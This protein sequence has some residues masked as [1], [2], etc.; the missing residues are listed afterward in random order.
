M[1]ILRYAS[2]VLKVFQQS[3]EVSPSV[4]SLCR[5]LLS[6]QIEELKLGCCW[7]KE[8]QEFPERYKYSRKEVQVLCQAF[9]NN[10]SL[11]KVSIGWKLDCS[12]MRVLLEAIAALPNLRSLTLVLH[13]WIPESAVKAICRCQSLRTLD[14][15]G[16]RVRVPQ[17]GVV[18]NAGSASGASAAANAYATEDYSRYEEV[19]IVSIMTHLA[20]SRTIGLSNVQTLKLRHCGILDQDITK[21]CADLKHHPLQELSLSANR[22]IT[23]KG[24]SALLQANN[25]VVLQKLDLTECGLDMEDCQGIS[26]ALLLLLSSSSNASSTN[27]TT[28]T[29]TYSSIQELS[30][31]R[32]TELAA[33]GDG[34][35]FID[36]FR[37]AS[38]R[39]RSLD[40]SYCHLSGHHLSDIFQILQSEDCT[41]ESLMLQG[42]RNVPG[43]ALVN[44]VARNQSLKRLV[45]NCRLLGA[46]GAA[47]AGRPR[48]CCYPLNRHVVQ[49]LVEVIHKNFRLQKLSLDWENGIIPAE[50]DFY[51]Q[52]NRAGRSILQDGVG[53]WNNVLAKVSNQPD[54]LFWLLQNGAGSMCKHKQHI[55]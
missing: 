44:V 45:L 54:A 42:C 52:L 37:V 53:S 27:T 50:L 13:T 15:R 7:K 43:P 2:Q 36:L 28:T 31:A 46:G 9:S 30:L 48:K 41:L 4:E 10:T 1:T 39:L 40:L 11:Q 55:L 26:E 49:E 5:R 35:S 20:H 34:D 6:D 8:E 21:L 18:M 29:T 22:G 17:S 16:V 24:V 12:T 38:T 33:S 14:I 19:N 47:A 32:N 23:S 51:L 3:P 25:G